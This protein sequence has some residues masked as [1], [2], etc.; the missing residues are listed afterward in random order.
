MLTLGFIAP[1]QR[2]RAKG[3]YYYDSAGFVNGK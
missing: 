1:I 3:V 2:D